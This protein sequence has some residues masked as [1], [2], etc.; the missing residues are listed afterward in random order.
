VR[1]RWTANAEY[2]VDTIWLHI[3]KDKLDAADRMIE[4]FRRA[5]RALGEH[6]LMGKVRRE[7]GART[8]VV[9]GTPYIVFYR[10]QH[11]EVVVL[12]VLHCARKWPPNDA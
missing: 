1:I 2:D 8:F 3:A 6:P 12:R 11:G 10:V 7:P 5:A 9:S 4:R